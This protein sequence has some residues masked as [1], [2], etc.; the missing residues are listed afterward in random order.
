M[1]NH[2]HDHNHYSTTNI[3]VE[4][5]RAPTDDAIRL[6]KEYEEKI[7]ASVIDSYVVENNILTATLL[8]MQVGPFA[9]TYAAF[10]LNGRHIHV[11]VDPTLAVLAASNEFQA[12]MAIAKAIAEAITSEIYNQLTVGMMK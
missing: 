5:K 3:K 8:Q 4:E 1:F 12:R 9:K 2:R 11:E 10:M 7:R 6:A